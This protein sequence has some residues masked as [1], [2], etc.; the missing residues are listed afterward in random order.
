MPNRPRNLDYAGI[1][2]TVCN[3]V[4]LRVTNQTPYDVYKLLS[5]GIFQKQCSK[6]LQKGPCCTA[7][8]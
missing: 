6:R 4:S 8:A 2:F 1:A 5:R 7:V 3:I